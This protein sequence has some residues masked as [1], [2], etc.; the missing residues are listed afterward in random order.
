L[1]DF[2]TPDPVFLMCPPEHFAIP[3][4]PPGAGHANEMCA[5]GREVYASD[6]AAFRRRAMDKWERYRAIL[7]RDLGAEI[8]LL[9][10][11]PALPDQVFAADASISLTW[12]GEHAQEE[13]A[14][15]LSRFTYAERQAEAELHAE[16]IARYAPDRHVRRAEFP[17]EGCGDNVYDP[18][19][20]LFWSGCTPNPG[21]THAG[22]G[23]SDARAHAQ[24]AA[25]TGV[26]VESLEVRSP[27]FHLDTALAVLPFGHLLVC[28]DGLAP[29]AFE[30]LRE[31][32]F[33][34]FGLDPAEHLI[35]VAKEDAARY[36]CN[37]VARGHLVVL[38][39]ISEGLLQIIRDRDYEPITTDFTEFIHSGGG[40][41]CLVNQLNERRYPGKV[42]DPAAP[43][44]QATVR[45]G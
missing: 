35:E 11:N 2:T 25:L 6:P 15:L 8:H 4:P 13:S 20:D 23:R 1:P 42:I 39:E 37:I 22:D 30:K 12:T 43:E 45:P 18:K 21:R 33:D 14:A 17:I 34:P 19:R 26:R 7:E 29:R 36:A 44:R 41:H 24:L 27:F 28:R 9:E 3:E 10:P 31:L 40:P 5:R 32:A 16:A 38:P